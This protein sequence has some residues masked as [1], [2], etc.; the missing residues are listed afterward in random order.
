VLQARSETVWSQTERPPLVEKAGSAL[1]YVL[2]DLLSRSGPR[3][4]DGMP[5]GDAA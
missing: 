4:P 1:D 2:A 3:A 5:T